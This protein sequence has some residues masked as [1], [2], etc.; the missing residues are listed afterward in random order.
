MAQRAH[1]AFRPRR[2][3]RQTVVMAETA[4]TTATIVDTI[5]LKN[6]KLKR[7]S[8]LAGGTLI[9]F[10]WDI[11]GIV[12]V[13]G[14]NPRAQFWAIVAD[15][16]FVIGDLPVPPTGGDL[17]AFAPYLFVTDIASHTAGESPGG[18]NAILNPDSPMCHIDVKSKRM[19]E[20]NQRIFIC[21]KT[22]AGSLSVT[23][24]IK[25]WW[26]EPKA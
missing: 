11:S 7:L 3:G 10:Q 15:S 24:L 22:S 13:S 1:R 12:T 21:A 19:L 20:D 14:T 16:D 4:T 9:R 17:D 18:G 26:K 25:F 8:Q 23:G 5:A 2:I 6:L